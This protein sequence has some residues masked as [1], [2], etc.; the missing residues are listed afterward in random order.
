MTT[1]R[2]TA[3]ALTKDFNKNM[4]SRM[5]MQYN[6]PS[7]ITKNTPIF[8]QAIDAITSTYPDFD[9]VEACFLIRNDMCSPG[10]CIHC[11]VRVAFRSGNTKEPYAKFCSYACRTAYQ[12]NPAAE[13]IVIDNI[14]YIDF[15]SAMAAIG[16]NRATIRRKIFDS[17]DNTYQW[18][19]NHEETCIK[20]LQQYSKLLVD[21]QQLTEWA[22]SKESL[23]S[24]E[25]RTGIDRE[26]IRCAFSFFGIDKT[27][28]QISENA[29]AVRDNKQK[30]EELYAQFTTEEIALMIDVTPKTV[31]NWLHD[32]QIPIDYSR[33]QSKIERDMIQYISE[34]APELEII[35]MDRTTIGIELD[36][37][38]PEKKFAIEFDGLR[39]H[40]IAPT[41]KSQ[42]KVH[43]SKRD[44][45]Y[46]EN[47]TLMRF[48]DIGETSDTNKLDIVKSMI[49]NRVGKSNRIWARK[50]EVRM[51]DKS[52]A[53]SFFE[54]NHLSGN[55]GS[56]ICYGLYFNDELVECMSFGKPLMD[57]KYDWEIIRLA[58]KKY[59]T[60][61]GGAS[62]L[63]NHF[64]KNNAGSVMTYVDCRHGN[65][66]VY[67][68]IGMNFVRKTEPGYFYTNM[69]RQFSRYEFQYPTIKKHCV[70]Y[71]DTL[72]E[73]ENAENTG[74]TIYW[75]CG[76]LVYEL[77]R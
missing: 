67:K 53:A 58:T 38:V 59:T 22:N 62:K 28:E 5:T 77:I 6:D 2:N 13:S 61:V 14:T 60:V 39:Y 43:A 7:I 34:I 40:S 23:S 25:V 44:L 20:K 8:K 24:I 4:W 66:K 30:L 52:V 56:N 70:N 72:T 73:F 46:R 63:F 69:K 11:G 71:D 57:K 49:C 74:F 15:P 12:P 68:E 29:I 55:R 27:F 1:P 36:I 45:C 9:F 18:A 31:Q 16:L 47:I 41:N 51:V 35:P 17:C 48:V 75:N 76:N 26:L 50:C 33:S 65:G 32:H 10:C 64:L 37:Y 42:R 3:R 54:Q 19:N 21:K